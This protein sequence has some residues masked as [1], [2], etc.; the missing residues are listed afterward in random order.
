MVKYVLDTDIISLLQQG[1]PQTSARFSQV[2]QAEVGI[3]VIS[4]E[5]QLSSWYT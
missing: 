3:S 4:V 2:L 1:H 5:E